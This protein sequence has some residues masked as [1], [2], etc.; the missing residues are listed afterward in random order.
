MRTDVHGSTGMVVRCIVRIAE[1]PWTGRRVDRSACRVARRDPC[2]GAGR[3]A[4]FGHILR[5][6][7]VLL[8]MPGCLG[9]STGPCVGLSVPGIG[10]ARLRRRVV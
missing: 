8:G 1:M 4:R 2:V 7:S 5:R 6:R 9:A 3:R 10:G